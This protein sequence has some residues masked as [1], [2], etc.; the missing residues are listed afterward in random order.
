MASLLMDASMY[1]AIINA[2]LLFGLTLVY[3]RIYR[4]TKA[5]FSLGLVLFA[6]ILLAQN[7]LAAYS[8]ATM[9]GFIG[10]PFLPYLLVINIAQVLGVLVLFRTTLR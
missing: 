6:S 2:V 7:L 3:T 10:D 9:S 4:D 1:T 8:F 5:Q